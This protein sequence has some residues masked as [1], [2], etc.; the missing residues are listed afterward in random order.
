MLI[1]L[2]RQQAQ[3]AHREKLAAVAP[4]APMADEHWA[5][6]R[7]LLLNGEQVHGTLEDFYFPALA[8]MRANDQAEYARQLDL[9]FAALRTMLGDPLPAAPVPTA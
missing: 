6:R 5:A 1:A 3:A 8:A 4:A 2:I 7:E 9:V